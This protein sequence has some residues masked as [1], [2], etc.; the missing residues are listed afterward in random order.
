MDQDFTASHHIAGALGGVLFSK[1]CDHSDL[2]VAGSSS[3]SRCLVGG[4]V[5]GSLRGMTSSDENRI[6]PT[7]SG[8]WTCRGSDL[9]LWAADDVGPE[10]DASEGRWVVFY[11]PDAF[12]MLQRQGSASSPSTST[13]QA[14][15]PAVS[16]VD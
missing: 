13:T 5:F 15:P 1:G 16:T 6:W 7:T 14:F 8:M 11:C 10:R 3:I 2:F 4:Q 9:A 12:W